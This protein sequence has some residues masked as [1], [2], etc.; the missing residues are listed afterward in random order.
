MPMGIV[1]ATCENG[2][3]VTTTTT[4]LT[5]TTLTVTTTTSTTTTP[6]TVPATFELGS[7]VTS[8]QRLPSSCETSGNAPRTVTMYVTVSTTGRQ[9]VFGQGNLDVDVWSGVFTVYISDSKIG[10]WGHCEDWKNNRLSINTNQWTH[11]ALVWDGSK[12]TVFV[13][14][15]SEVMTLVT[16]CGGHH[17]GFKTRPGAWVAGRYNEVSSRLQISDFKYFNSALSASEIAS[18]AALPRTA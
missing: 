15:N 5:S 9:Y 16:K 11:L 2:C 17:Q 8:R 10:I 7:L 6:A 18:I 4:T 3:E 12:P 14:G 13:D 1:A